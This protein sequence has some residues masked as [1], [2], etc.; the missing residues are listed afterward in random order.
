MF[1]HMALVISVPLCPTGCLRISFFAGGSLNRAIPPGIATIRVSIW[2]SSDE[3]N[4]EP[5]NSHGELQLG[6]LLNILISTSSM[7]HDGDQETEVSIQDVYVRSLS[8]N[9]GAP[10]P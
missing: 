10:S 3:A 5:Y 7:L 1:L 2:W 6:V 9:F 4:R 8:G